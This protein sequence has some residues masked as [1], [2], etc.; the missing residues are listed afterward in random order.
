MLDPEESWEPEEEIDA[1]I[2]YIDHIR[3]DGAYEKTWGIRETTDPASPSTT[4]SSP[5]KAS[6]IE[7][8]FSSMVTQY[9]GL[10]RLLTQTNLRKA[11]MNL[12]AYEVAGLQHSIPV[13][14]SQYKAYF[15]VNKIVNYVPGQLT[16]VEL[17]KL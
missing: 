7:I 12:P 10:S 1:R 3:K 2:V 9:A 17:I 16:T 13:Y 15:Y 14:L 4:V 8:S 6:T 5:K 11:K